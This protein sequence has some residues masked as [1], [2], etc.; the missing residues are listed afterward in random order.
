MQDLA[1]WIRALRTQLGLTQGQ[2]AQRL[3]VTFV[4]VSRWE[5]RQVYPSRLALRLLSALAESTTDPGS[6]TTK[7]K[8]AFTNEYRPRRRS[9][10][11]GPPSGS[12]AKS[13]TVRHLFG[14]DEARLSATAAHDDRLDILRRSPVFSDLN[15]KQLVELSRLCVSR[16]VKSGECL[17]FEGDLV[18]SL[19]VVAEGRVK[20]LKHS[21]SGKDFIV[22]FSAPGAMLGNV[23]LLSGKPHPTSA[24][25]VIDT[26]ALVIGKDD[27][28]SFVSEHLELGFKILERMLHVVGMRHMYATR[29]LADLAA[30]RVDRRLIETL[31][32]L[33]LEFGP[34]LPFT[35]EEIAQMSGTTT[36]ST[37]RF[38]KRLRREGIVSPL[39]QKLTILDQT[40]LRSWSKG[41]PLA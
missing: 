19:Y 31:V 10:S 22:A 30:E 40:K 26:S 41:L 3:G 35:R 7:A 25:A 37:I 28:L 20:V 27:F 17:Y 8:Q 24:Q 15:K 6:S 11:A 34:A 33:S 12:C 29:R 18:E 32:T 2:F 39:G 14:K 13:V 36:E 9:T 1:D 38:V 5:N 4:T 16:H 23:A 21:P